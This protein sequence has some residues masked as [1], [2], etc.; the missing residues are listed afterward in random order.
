MGARWRCLIIMHSA[1]FGNQTQHLTIN[2]S[3]V[4][5]GGGGVMIW[6]CYAATGHRKFAVIETMTPLYTRMFLKTNVRPCDQQ[7]K[8]SLNRV[9]QQ[10]N[11]LKCTSKLAC[12]WPMK[13]KNN[14]GVGIAKSKSKPH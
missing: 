11:D 3:T 7:L 8:L 9:M 10:D 14:H 4:K 12:V 13:K 1:M 5:H 6:A 2:T